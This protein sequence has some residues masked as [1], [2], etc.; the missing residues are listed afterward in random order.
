VALSRNDAW[1][2]GSSVRDY[3]PII[4][5]W[6]GTNW[7]VVPS[8]SFGG[9]TETDLSSI[10]ASS[11]D[12]IW[13]VGQLT[14]EPLIE[15]WDGT[16]W[17]LKRIPQSHWQYWSDHRMNAI[18]YGVAAIATDDVWTTGFRLEH[19]DGQKWHA[20]SSRTGGSAIGASSPRDVWDVGGK[21]ITHYGCR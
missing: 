19:W 21:R 11:A 7:K 13:A 1:A 17:T 16:R 9:G 12:D 4:E 6:D 20:G 5:H 2:V 14:I 15:H 3:D 8:V 18:L 10:S